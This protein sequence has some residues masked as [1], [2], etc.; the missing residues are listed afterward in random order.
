MKGNGC[1]I[2]NTGA[3]ED[4]QTAAHRNIEPVLSQLPDQLHVGKAAHP[5]RI[6]GGDRHPFAEIFNQVS[7]NASTLAFNIG[8]MD[9]KFRAVSGKIGK[10]LPVD[11]DLGK[12]LPG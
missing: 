10:R 1:L 3:A 11:S 12:F 9:Q 4:I 5:A 8:G 2:G 7:G 6:G